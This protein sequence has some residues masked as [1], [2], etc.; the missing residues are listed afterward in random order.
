[1]KRPLRTSLIFFGGVFAITGILLAAWT[2]IIALSSHDVHDART[3]TLT[4]GDLVID[5]D[6]GG[7]TLEPGEPGRVIV[8]R[9]ITDSINGPDPTW[10]L[11]G[12]RLKLRLNCPSFLGVSCGGSYRIKVP[13]DVP[14]RVGADNGS[15][16]ASGLRQDMQFTTSNGHIGIDDS[17]GNL[18][19]NTDNGGVSVSRVNAD[20]VSVQTDNGG[21]RLRF[22]TAPTNV[23]VRTDNGGVHLS[24]PDDHNTY[25]VSTHTDN[26]GVNNDIGNDTRSNR[27]IDVRT[28]N[29]GI[30]MNL[31]P[32][33]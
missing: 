18:S 29:G 10:T 11:Q 5:T 6:N 25:R 2:G 32:V 27:V 15:I 17:T 16:T 22:D 24:V 21:V 30:E 3:F 26:G 7:V 31:V 28:D 12:N 23:K 20:R 14:L 8:D 1:M 19:L 9:R 13:L 4:T 33:R